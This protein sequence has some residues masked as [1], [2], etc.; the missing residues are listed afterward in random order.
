MIN[1]QE[2]TNAF[3][4]FS[5][6]SQIWPM[7]ILHSFFFLTLFNCLFAQDSISVLFIGNSYTTAN[8]LPAMVNA[9]TLSL[10]DKLTF[11]SKANGGFT[12][13]QHRNDPATYV[14]INSQPWDF[15]VLQG[16]SQEPSF[17]YTQVNEMTLPYAV[18]LA[19]SIYANRYCSQA[20]YFMTWGRENGDPQWDSIATFHGMNARL[21]NAYLRITDSAQACVS[22]VGS[23]W[24]YVRDNYPAIQLYS[25]GSHPSLAGSYLAA[26]TFYAS[27]FRKSP[28]GATYLAGLDAATAGI[29]QEAATLAVLDSLDLWHLRS[30]EDIAIANFTLVVNGQTVSFTDQS[31]RAQNY[32]WDFGD[33]TNSAD[34]HPIHAYSAPGNYQVELIVS[35]ECGSDTLVSL[36][37]ILTSEI[38]EVSDPFFRVEAHEYGYL[39]ELSALPEEVRVLTSDGRDLNAEQILHLEDNQFKVDL[40]DQPRGIYFVLVSSAEGKQTIKLSW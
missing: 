35:N 17:P 22:P 38:V 14:K 23:A 9:L 30:T 37:E 33:G 11:D 7:K 6:E 28:V 39:L 4:W 20:M 18:E 19:D 24:K 3:G 2:M 31:W 21:R 36:V 29:M 13:L 1:V 12:F 16:Q 10:G 40:S 34:Q 32:S 15:V 26:C 5:E 27:L 25:D 8:N